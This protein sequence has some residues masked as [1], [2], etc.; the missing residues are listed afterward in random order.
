MR[1]NNVLF[2]FGNPNQTIAGHKETVCRL[3]DIAEADQLRQM[4]RRYGRIAG[5]D[6]DFDQGGEFLGREKP[7]GM[8]SHHLLASKQATCRPETRLLFLGSDHR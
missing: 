8:N 3:K 7:G 1:R 6:R 2:A 5:R 4:L